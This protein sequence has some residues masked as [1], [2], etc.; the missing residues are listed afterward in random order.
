[1]GF[2]SALARLALVACALEDAWIATQTNYVYSGWASNLNEN[3][4]PV[5]YV[6]HVCSTGSRELDSGRIGL[7]AEHMAQCVTTVQ[8]YFHTYF[9]THQ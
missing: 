6:M 4:N 7:A 2:A 3:I 9:H 5:E 1:M 8:T